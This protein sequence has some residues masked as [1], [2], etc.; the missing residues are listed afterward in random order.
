MATVEE[1]LR[2]AE[3]ELAAASFDPPRREAKLLLSRV[4]GWNE[5]RVLSRGEVPIGEANATCFRELLQRRLTGEPVA[6]LLGEK[7][8]Y[9][10]FFHVDPRVLIPRPETEHL[11]EAALELRLPAAA[12]ILDLGTGSG[13][14]AVTLACEIP[15]SFVTAV[16]KSIGATAV[17]RTNIARHG[18][19]DRV[20][21]LSAD[22]A[23]AID[24]RHFDLVVSNP[25]YV[26]P[27][28][29]VSVE[30]AGFEP[31]AAIFA[32]AGGLSIVR[33]LLTDLS[34]LAG[35]TPLCIEIGAGQA[36][37]VGRLLG[38]SPFELVEILPDL[39]AIPR[40]VLA[41]RR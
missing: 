34:P 30:V 31:A 16:D 25:P 13:C 1:L 28:E 32:P 19:D 12:R 11:V 27:E 39:A 14:L 29:P 22:L 8:F 4:L 10:R 6:Y 26:D 2:Y 38:S 9:G 33:R 17:A 23:S 37:T 41:R 18:V 35:G 36:A 3:G 21:L 40:V 20:L 15:G 5:A 7:E 24:V